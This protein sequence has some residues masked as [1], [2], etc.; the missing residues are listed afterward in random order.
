[1]TSAQNLVCS[2]SSVTNF[3]QWAKAISDFFA[4]CGWVKSSDTGQVNWATISSVP[5]AGAFVYEVWTPG[6]G[7]TAY[8]LK[9]EYGNHASSATT[10]TIRLSIGATTNG[11]GLLTG[12]I[13]GP[14]QTN[15]SNYTPPGGG[16]TQYVCRFSGTSGRISAQMWT[17]SGGANAEQFFSVE[18]SVNSSGVYTGTHVTLCTLGFNSTQVSSGCGQQS[19]VFG[20]GVPPPAALPWGVSVSG[21]GTTYSS[22]N[23]SR[24]FGVRTLQIAA[25]NS[26]AFNGG[27]SFELYAPYVGFWDHQPI[28]FGITSAVDMVEGLTFQVTVYGTLRTYMPAKVG[29]FANCDGF[30]NAALCMLWE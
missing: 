12:V 24:G 19:F 15:T 26:S 30:G 10:P 23:M 7:L 18:R 3:K 29:L 25:S 6:D 21:S 9:V 17:N 14:F 5:G 27:I 16:V 2:N 13:A 1:M 28:G 4:A 11:A 8:F 20:V 22:A